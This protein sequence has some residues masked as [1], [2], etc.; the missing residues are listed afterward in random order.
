MKTALAKDSRRLYRTIGFATRFY[1]SHNHEKGKKKRKIFTFYTNILIHTY[2]HDMYEYVYKTYTSSSTFKNCWR[3]EIKD[4]CLVS[5]ETI[6]RFRSV[7]DQQIIS[8]RNKM[9]L[10][11]A[12]GY[13]Q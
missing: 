7:V 1:R 6:S 12:H 3:I 13:D 10:K 4:D 9:I 5:L 8:D 11:A 2:I